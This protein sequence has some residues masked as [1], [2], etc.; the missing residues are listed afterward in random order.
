MSKEIRKSGIDI[1][2]DV[3]WGTQFCQLYQTKE[4]LTDILVP[5][6]KAGLENNEFC[7]WITSNLLDVEEA[8]K[9]FRKVIHDFDAYLE[10]GQIEI[11]PY[12]HWYAKDGLFNPQT[13]LNG[14]IKKLNQGMERD[15]EGLR[16]AEDV[17]WQEKE[18]WDNSVNYETN[19]DA[20]TSKYQMIALYTYSL[21]VSNVT[22][23]IDVVSN[24]QFT[25]VKKEGKWERIGNCGRRNL[26]TESKR[27]EEALYQS[28]QH[29]ET[30]LEDIPSYARDIANIDLAKI[31]DL[32]VIQ[33]LMDD[34][35][36]LTHIIFPLA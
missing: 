30:R 1:I 24:H 22:E 15:Y 7:L 14:L 19:L 23:V 8:K 27:T 36:K 25:L 31:I 33:S 6:F 12:T 11:I 16:L 21:I 32:Q 20:V 4:D 26:L 13:V 10:K 34:F 2:G 28:E 5:Y 29:F 17:S 3:P 18:D 35:Y 9:A